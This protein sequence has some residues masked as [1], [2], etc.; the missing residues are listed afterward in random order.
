MNLSGMASLA[1][2]ATDKGTKLEDHFG[3]E[4]RAKLATLAVQMQYTKEAL[5]DL[6]AEL[7]TGVAERQIALAAFDARL[8]VVENF[9]W[10]IM[11]VCGALSLLGGIVGHVALGR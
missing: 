1:P 2:P 9:R 3:P 4:D 10:W 8:R 6:R 5:Q 7:S 11:G